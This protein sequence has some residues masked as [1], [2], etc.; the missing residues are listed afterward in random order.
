[1]G[2]SAT[3]VSL[4]SREEALLIGS[5]LDYPDCR[6]CWARHRSSLR[7]VTD[8]VVGSMVSTVLAP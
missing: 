4:P 7:F 5:L 8:L 3:S 1:L 6:S 2:E